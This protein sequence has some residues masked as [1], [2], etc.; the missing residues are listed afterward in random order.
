MLRLAARDHAGSPSIA[1]STTRRL[2]TSGDPRWQ[3]I[4]EAISAAAGSIPK[5]DVTE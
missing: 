1:P 3:L 5:L 4:V 2:K